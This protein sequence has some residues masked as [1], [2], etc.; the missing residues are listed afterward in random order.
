ME[1]D[2]AVK[3]LFQENRCE[4]SKSS[5]QET[6]QL[7]SLLAHG[8]E[9]PQIHGENLP[10]L[11][12]S[13]Y[14]DFPLPFNLEDLLD[15]SSITI[16]SLL[17]S[18]PPQPIATKP[19]TTL[20]DSPF[21]GVP[22][23]SVPSTIPAAFFKD[24]SLI[25]GSDSHMPLS[26]PN[27]YSSDRAHSSQV[28]QTVRQTIGHTHP[29]FPWVPHYGK[30]AMTPR[31]S[32]DTPTQYQ[33]FTSARPHSFSNQQ[34][35]LVHERGQ[36]E[37]EQVR[38]QH[39]SPPVIQLNLVQHSQQQLMLHQLQQQRPTIRFP[40]PPF[41]VKQEPFTSKQEQ[42][43]RRQEPMKQ[44]PCLIKREPIFDK[45]DLRE[46]AELEK[47][48]MVIKQE[49]PWH[50]QLLRQQHQQLVS[51]L[52][53][54]QR[55]ERKALVDKL[56]R[57][58]SVKMDKD[59]NHPPQDMKEPLLEV[60]SAMENAA[61]GTSFTVQ[62]EQLAAKRSP[63]LQRPESGY[64]GSPL[65]FHS[66]ASFPS[67]ATPPP[68]SPPSTSYPFLGSPFPADIQNVHL[69]PMVK[70]E[71]PSLSDFHEAI[72][73]STLHGQKVGL[74]FV[75]EGLV[76]EGFPMNL[77]PVIKEEKKVVGG[78][79][80]DGKM[81]YQ[82]SECYKRFGQLSN[83]RVHYRTHTQ[84]R[85]YSCYMENKY[86]GSCGKTFKQ[87][88]HLQKHLMIHSGMKPHPCAFCE[89]RF[90]SS[91]NLKT[92]ERVHKMEKPYVCSM[93]E[94][95]FTQHIHLKQHVLRVHGQKKPHPCHSCTNAYFTKSS[96][97]QHLKSTSCGK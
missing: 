57:E 35:V 39:P 41:V 16:E 70:I 51:P 86:G 71:P 32:F 15:S 88:A 92:H 83:L 3:H 67:P 11:Q 2:E 10:V 58:M 25:S 46:A 24:S 45:L 79:K 84:V 52:L 34:N 1:D 40:A 47:D 85:P 19:G 74:P 28:N 4:G 93:C 20:R 22:P 56:L 82:C 69:A 80:I 89:K 48:V 72:L 44:E 7:E 13:D 53:E 36:E 33:Q 29:N 18:P 90:S 14:E 8:Q 63:S 76:Q 55:G 27:I 94:D 38:M 12:I 49:E 61:A 62:V 95:R 97:N 21:S 66:S 43:V 78:Q 68:S 6:P 96:L 73:K 91:S 9:D 37:R 81:V 26:S 5:G 65:S 75:Q 17:N 31:N 77:Q 23:F 59:P 64:H 42:W 60:G 50:Q 87:L 30:M 54:K